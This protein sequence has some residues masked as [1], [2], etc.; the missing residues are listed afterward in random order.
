M[1]GNWLAL[2][3]FI[4]MMGAFIFE[5]IHHSK[6]MAKKDELLAA[7]SYQEFKYYQ[8]LYKEELK[9]LKILRN[10]A[11]KERKDVFEEVELE[12]DKMKRPVD[13]MRT[14]FDEDWE[15]EELDEDKLAQKLG[16]D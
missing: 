6:E 16:I 9:E 7:K 14:A 1:Q 2:I 13:I 8:G 15:K 10:E 4:L 5:R 3:I 12:E 11:R